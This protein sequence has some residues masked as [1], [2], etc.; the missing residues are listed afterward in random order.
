MI[1]LLSSTVCFFFVAAFSPSIARA[2]EPKSAE[3]KPLFNG[4][5]L[6]GWYTVIGKGRSEDPNHLAQ[7]D[8]GM[9]HM[10]KD[11]PEGSSQPTGYIVTEKEYSDYHFRVDYKWGTKRFEPRAKVRRDAGILYHIVG[12]DGVWPRSVECQIQENDVGDVF[13]VYTRLLACVDAATTNRVANLVTN[14][15]GVV[16]TNFSVLPVYLD[17][18]RGGISFPQ[19]VGDGIR[20]VIRNPMNEHDGWNT[21]EIIVHGDEATYLV[22]GKVNNR[23]TK[24]EQMQ[25]GHWTPLTKGKICLQLEFAEVFYRNAEIK[26]FAR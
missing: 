18:A 21:V 26:E 8:H 12:K 17:A 2:G 10:Y 16:R 6:N 19:G 25:E 13:T 20:R 11:A 5:N 3:W 14:P 22:N 24:I 1:R 4:T 15:A 7:V 9:V 23:V